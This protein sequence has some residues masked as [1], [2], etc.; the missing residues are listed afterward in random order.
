MVLMREGRVVEHTTIRLGA[1]YP[2]DDVTVKMRDL[3]NC[4]CV[5]R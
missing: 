4:I 2:P 5:F 3:V 1:S